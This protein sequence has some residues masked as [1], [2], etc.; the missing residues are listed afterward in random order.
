MGNRLINFLQHDVQ[1]SFLI[2]NS[3]IKILCIRLHCVFPNDN[4]N[5]HHNKSPCAVL[6]LYSQIK[7][8][9][10][11]Y[12]QHMKTMVCRDHASI[13]SWC[14]VT[15]HTGIQLVVCDWIYGQSDCHV[16]GFRFQLNS[17]YIQIAFTLF[18]DRNIT[19]WHART[20]TEETWRYSST[21][22][23]TWH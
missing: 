13:L 15:I 12:T 23:A 22:F 16:L 18:K 17:L 4:N 11:C 7:T 8:T 10:V 3:T 1:D 14:N 9:H 19:P 20:D 21:P 6:Y 5:L 2:Q